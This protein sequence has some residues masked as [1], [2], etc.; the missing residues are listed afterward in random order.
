[1]LYRLILAVLHQMNSSFRETTQG[2]SDQEYW[3]GGFNS[4]HSEGKY[5]DHSS[6]FAVCCKLNVYSGKD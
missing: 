3:M 2:H 4:G 1:M 5:G 6:G